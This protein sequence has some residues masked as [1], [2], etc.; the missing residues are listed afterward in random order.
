M[1][2][3]KSFIDPDSKVRLSSVDLIGPSIDLRPCKVFDSNVMP[4]MLQN[5]VLK[6]MSSADC[7]KAAANRIRKLG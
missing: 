7:V 3:M 1:M 4:E 2:Q 5:K 6:N